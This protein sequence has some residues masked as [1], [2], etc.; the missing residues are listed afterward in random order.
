MEAK[1]EFNGKYANWYYAIFHETGSDVYKKR[2][3]RILNCLDFW[4]WDAYHENEVLDLRKTNRCN[5]NRFCSNCRKWDL[6]RALYNLEKPFEKLV[7]DGYY[8]YLVTVTVP[9]VW[10]ED[11][12]DVI[13]KISKCFR[14]FY[15]F[16]SR[17]DTNGFKGRYVKFDAALRCLEITYN[18]KHGFHVHSH[19]LFFS[20]VWNEDLFYKY[21][22]GPFSRRMNDY[23]FYSDMDI[24]IMKLWKICWDGLRVS[25][26]DSMSSNWWDLYQCDIRPMNF[27]GIYEV[28]KYSFKDT[29]VLDYRVFK[30]LVGALENMRIRQGYGLLHGV[31]LEDIEDGGEKQ[32]LLSYLS[33]NK[34]EFPEQLAT[35]SLET[36]YNKYANYIKI[37]RFNKDSKFDKIID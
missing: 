19:A 35:R 20:D 29:D 10:H 32:D 12:R 8:P 31:K 21:I 24:Q 11:V 28:L 7:R 2:S 1:Q 17:D 26:Y 14:K 23:L 6:S 33:V 27:N 34:E 22:E 36:L 16:L 13:C 3:K 5:M 9:S 4:L 25:K 18:T 30:T 15:H 37:S